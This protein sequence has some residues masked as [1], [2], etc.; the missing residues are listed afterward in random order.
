MNWCAPL[1]APISSTDRLRHYHA[2]P[3]ERVAC[4][5]GADDDLLVTWLTMDL[6]RVAQVDVTLSNAEGRLLRRVEDVPVDHQRN[7]IIY[8]LG[9]DLA[10]TFPAMTFHVEVV[11]VAPEGRRRLA[12]YTFDHTPLA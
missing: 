12:E 1:L 2:R 3:G 5:V 4:T 7:E 10:R 11:A 9:G 6:E 8:S